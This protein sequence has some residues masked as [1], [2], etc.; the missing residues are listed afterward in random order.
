MIKD[1][2]NENQLSDLPVTQTNSK[3]TNLEIQSEITIN[4]S[5]IETS[6]G[7]AF[8]TNR[9]DLKNTNTNDILDIQNAKLSEEVRA[10]SAQTFCTNAFNM[11]SKKRMSA[12]L[13]TKDI[14]NISNVPNELYDLVFLGDKDVSIQTNYFNDR[15]EGPIRRSLAM[16]FA[17]NAFNMSRGIRI[18]TVLPINYLYLEP[19]PEPEVQDILNTL[20]GI[21]GLEYAIWNHSPGGT[22]FSEELTQSGYR[23]FE[24]KS[25][26]PILGESYFDGV[27]IIEIATIIENNL[28]DANTLYRIYFASSTGYSFAEKSSVNKK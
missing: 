6:D 26:L 5:N 20:T 9:T 10:T 12:G 23:L 11:A 21:S 7:L 16:N 8:C 13:K 17:T 1:N 27:S 25:D 19:E 14:F 3:Q 2:L 18:N 4:D 24:S 28:L 22:T 15:S